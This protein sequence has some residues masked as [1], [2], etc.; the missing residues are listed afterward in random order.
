KGNELATQQFFFGEVIWRLA[1]YLWAYAMTGLLL[2]VLFRHVVGA[3]V[4]LFLVPTT[5]EPLLGLLLKENTKYL[6]FSALDQVISNGMLSSVLAH[7]KAAL[8]FGAYLAV[9]WI[10]A[11]FLF[12]RRDAN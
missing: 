10:I 11:W 9:G 4:T 1:F 12:L 5:V 7:N 6:P 8:L 3:L 2:G